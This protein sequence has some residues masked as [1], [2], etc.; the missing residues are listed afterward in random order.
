ML[1]LWWLDGAQLAAEQAGAWSAALSK[2][3]GSLAYSLGAA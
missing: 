3:L 1:F 2:I